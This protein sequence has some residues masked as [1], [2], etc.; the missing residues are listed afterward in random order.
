MVQ[1]SNCIIEVTLDK[2]SPGEYTLDIHEF[3]DISKGA[4]RYSNLIS[5]VQYTFNVNLAVEMFIT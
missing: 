1:T 2:M 4:D 5:P 3:G